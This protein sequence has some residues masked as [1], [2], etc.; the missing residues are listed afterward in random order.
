[1][2]ET[3][4]FDALEICLQ[5][6]EKGASVEACLALFPGLA[7]ELRPMLQTASQA[8][9][10]AV[11]EVPEVVASRGKARL[12]QAAAEMRKQAGIAPVRLTSGKK[13]FLGP[14]FYRLAASA[15]VVVVFLLTGGTGL[16]NAS[17]GAIPG[18]RLYP[19]KR[20]W[21]GVR[22]FFVFDQ[23]SKT[24][25]ETEFE[26]ERFKEIHELYTEKRIAQV[27]FQGVV[28]SSA[29][30]VWVIGGLNIAVS[31]ET[32]FP[33]EITP[34]SVVEVD[35]ET[36]DSLIKARSIRIIATPG[37]TPIP[38]FS[39]SPIPSSTQL[40][41]PEALHSPEPSET[42]EGQQTGSPGILETPEPFHDGE[43]TAGSSQNTPSYTSEP[44]TETHGGG[45]GSGTSPTAV[46]TEDSHPTETSH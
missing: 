39:P 21:E 32:V 16:V 4:I 25:L 26:N 13:G 18:D 14:R 34:G 10:A 37:T 40:A 38:G 8:K 22:L 33:A 31:P 28:Q 42:M 15:F 17:T 19:V 44:A 43:S 35:G 20:S 5:A 41:T 2:T 23:S 36:D 7:D 11:S 30:D 6:L 29:A 1:M 3:N 45:S 24:Q 27:N 46:K 12:L 9:A